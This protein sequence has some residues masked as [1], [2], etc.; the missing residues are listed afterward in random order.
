MS[1]GLRNRGEENTFFEVLKVFFM[2]GHS[3]ITFR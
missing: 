1:K 2:A 3:T